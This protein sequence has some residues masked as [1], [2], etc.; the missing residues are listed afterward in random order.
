MQR[1][2]NKVVS[3]L[4]KRLRT[5]K[6]PEDWRW[7]LLVAVLIIVSVLV[8]F[9]DYLFPLTESEKWILRVIDLSSV[10]IIIIDYIKRLRLSND[11]RSFIL[12]HWYE[13]PAMLPLFVTGA[14]EIASSGILSYIRFIAIF[15]LIRLYNL[16]YYIKGGELLV[17]ATLSAIS[18][19]F[20]ALG[21]YIT[22][23]GQPGANI[24]N[25]NDAFW[26]SIETITTVAYGEYYPVTDFGK[27]V[28]GVMMFAAI[29][30]LWTFV[31]LLGSTLVSTR[32]K[33]EEAS[34]PATVVNEIKEI[35]KEKIEYVEEM[36]MNEMEDLI[37]II[38]SLN[39]RNA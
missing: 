30:F 23:V 31:G 9:A 27:I 32:K 5:A 35:I 29:G 28:A 21:I 10:I 15:R 7:D 17:L 4:N 33:Q 14:P 12:K 13:L 2:Y 8:V 16:W 22:E 36:D 1:A 3:K 20:G 18:I 34:G 25:L 11:W 39:P 19:I 6:K 24:S 26:W 37:R 38:R